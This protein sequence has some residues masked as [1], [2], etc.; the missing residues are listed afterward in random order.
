MC[1]EQL[2]GYFVSVYIWNGYAAFPK[3]I[4]KQETTTTIT[5]TVAINFL[6]YV[7]MC[8]YNELYQKYLKL[9]LFLL[10]SFP[11]QNQ[12]NRCNH[13]KD[14]KEAK[15]D[16]SQIYKTIIL[17]VLFLLYILPFFSSRIN[18]SEKSSKIWSYYI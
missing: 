1:F 3:P 10:L 6:C 9:F 17:F 18:V 8:A 4:I 14:T 12:K 13:S 2:R 7:S 5:K 15:N 11:H 16:H